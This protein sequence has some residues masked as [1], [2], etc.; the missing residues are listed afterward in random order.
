LKV[1][2][3]KIGLPEVGATEIGTAEVGLA[4]VGPLEI[5]SAEVGIAKV[6]L[7]IRVLGPPLVPSLS[8]NELDEFCIGHRGF[9]PDS[10]LAFSCHV[11]ETGQK[12]YSILSAVVG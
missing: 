11:T 2:P 12:A 4:E 8:L 1:G 9:L 10:R 5:C 3:A 7:L 6:Q